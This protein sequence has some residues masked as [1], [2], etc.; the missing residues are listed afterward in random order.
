MDLTRRT[1]KNL[2][3]CEKKT[4]KQ[5]PKKTTMASAEETLK[6]TAQ[7]QC[8]KKKEKDKERWRKEKKSASR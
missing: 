7:I 8:Y 5:K 2:A 3:I 4:K 1:G 6:I